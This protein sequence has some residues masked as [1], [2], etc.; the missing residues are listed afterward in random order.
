ML[1][2]SHL[3]PVTA[4]V[5][6]VF[7][8]SACSHD[9][10]QTSSG[11]VV[12]EAANELGAAI[13]GCAAGGYVALTK[14]LT[15][16]LTGT[17]A[18]LSAPGGKIAANGNI[19]MNSGVALTT[20]TVAKIVVLGQ[21]TQDDKLV[22]DLQPGS[23]GTTIFGATGGIT[24]DFSLSKSGAF[25]VRGST[26]ADKYTFGTLDKGTDVYAELSGDK[27]AD[28]HIIKA[29]TLAVSMGAGADT[30]NGN[31]TK[32]ADVTSFAGATVAIGPLAATSPITVYGGAG[33]DII[34][35]GL[36]NDLLFGGD[37]D[38][39]FKAASVYDGDDIYY[40]GDGTI[41]GDTSTNDTVDF[42]A[43]TAA[44]TVTV[45]PK[46]IDNVTKKFT[47]D[48]VDGDPA[49]NTT[50]ELDDVAYDVE[51]VIGGGGDDT[52]TGSDRKNIL[53]GG[54]GADTIEGSANATCTDATY[55]DI[56]NGG[57]GDD[58][59]KIAAGN[60]WVVLNGGAGSDTAD[61]SARTKDLVITID[62][63]A[64]DGDATVNA[65]AGEKANVMGDVEVVKTGS[66]ND[67]IT[68]SANADIL[69]GGAG[70]DTLNGGAG[71]DILYGEAGNDVLNGNAGA[72][73]LNGGAGDD[74][75]NGGAGVDIVTYAA[76]LGTTTVAVTLCDDPLELAGAP[77]VPYDA[78]NKK[79]CAAA[80][81]GDSKAT[82]KDQVVNCEWVKGGLGDDTI[83]ADPNGTVDVTLEGGAG[84]DVLTGGAG[85]DTIFGDDGDDT[86]AGGGGDD[87]LEGGDGDD[88]LD[89][90]ASDGD[91]CVADAL[92]QVAAVAC[93]L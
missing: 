46:T 53:T 55:G 41:A 47:A 51:N 14:T 91:I 21:A 26:G 19:C 65:G 58:I 30:F 73:T 64:N 2:K 24:A 86:L 71:D 7:A 39:T 37:G 78:A 61:F 67:T 20:T 88:A 84:N 75:L 18:V 43:R 40:G 74:V 69:W 11:D 10:T 25:M 66:G 1:R 45:G 90:G 33:N 87:Y 59:L 27:V 38:D 22:I 83:T 56:L 48:A 42:S 62:A 77:T 16:T 81:D 31:P 36:G 5:L 34:T 68:G 28:V 17:T 49:M 35:G 9:S 63:T 29:G 80:N 57:L 15:L 70:T 54:A 50:G 93:E 23:F 4:L 13:T 79:G 44:I 89:G 12:E 3:F 32:A 76:Y 6:G 52:L 85:N 60:C 92:D 8:P 82:E 72:D